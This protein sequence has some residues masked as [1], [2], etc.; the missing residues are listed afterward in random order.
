MSQTTKRFVDTF[1]TYHIAFHYK[2]H[3][4][5]VLNNMTA[6]DQA[7]RYLPN[8]NRQRNPHESCP[9]LLLRIIFRQNNVF[10]NIV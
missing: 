8:V 4:R 6:L 3:L 2:D 5:M 9:I 10:E 1:L 7:D